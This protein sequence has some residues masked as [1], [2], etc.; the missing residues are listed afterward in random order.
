MNCKFTLL[1]LISITKISYSQKTEVGITAGVT[2]AN[3]QAKADNESET[4]DSKIGFTAGLFLQT[5]ISKKVFF[6]PA[7]NFVQKGFSAPD[8]DPGESDKSTLNYLEVP[9]NVI[10]KSEGFFA[11]AGPAISIGL[12]GKEKYTY[13][14]ETDT[15]DLSFGSDEDEIKQ[16]EFSGNILAGYEFKNGVVFSANYNVGF[17]NLLNNTQD[18]EGTLKNRYFGFRLGY[19]FRKK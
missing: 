15:D 2:V 11:G 13:N 17:S 6:A 4:A 14:G 10:F 7:I 16:V 5:S 3:V 8:M 19:V 9:L 1:L 12:S 18:F